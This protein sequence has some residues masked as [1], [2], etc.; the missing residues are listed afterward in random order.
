MTALPEAIRL[1]EL[2]YRVF[3]LASGA[4]IPLKDSAGCLDATDE[5]PRITAWFASSGYNI[6]LSTDGLVVVD[7]DDITWLAE[8]PDKAID[9]AKAPFQQTPR[10]G[11]HYIFRQNG[12]SVRNSASKIA[13]HIDI[14]A[15]GGY[16]VVEPSTVGGKAYAWIERIDCAPSDLP[17]PPAWLSDMIRTASTARPAA[18]ET[19]EIVTVGER[20]DWL[21]RR[22]CRYWNVS[23]EVSKVA[24]RL[25]ADNVA[26]CVPP[27]EPDE[28]RKIAESCARYESVPP[29]EP[30]ANHEWIK[31]TDGKHEL[32][33][34]HISVI[35]TKLEVATDGWPRRVGDLLFVDERGEI[36][37]LERAD[38]VYSWMHGKAT[39]HWKTGADKVGRTLV[40]KNEFAAHL[41]QEAKAYQAVEE[42]PHQPAIPEIYYS[43]KA[44]RGY[45]AEGGALMRLLGFFDNCATEIDTVLLYAM[46]LTP[47]WGGR[48]G[49][50]PAFVVVSTDRGFGK[51]EMADAIAA[52]YGGA[53]DVGNS[54]HSDEK[55]LSRILSPDA[56]TR[57]ILRFDNV[58]IGADSATLENLITCKEIS[59]HRLYSGEAT[60]PNY[61]TT[62]ITGNS[63]R[64]SRDL[65]ERAFIIQ[66]KKP[67]YACDWATRLNRHIAEHR[68]EIMADICAALK[69]PAASV[70][71]PNRHAEWC[72]EVLARVTNNPNDVIR[73]TISRRT[74]CD[75]DIEEAA[76]IMS[77]LTTEASK[78][79]PAGDFGFLA[80]T[81]VT[82]LLKDATGEHM[83][84]KAARSKIEQHIGAGRLPGITY[85]RGQTSRGYLVRVPKA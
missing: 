85:K 58:K 55:L 72:A 43:W 28:I 70:Q 57:R 25:N 82:N 71:V 32:N 12:E 34:V 65:A 16:I 42:L 47:A 78:N 79:A 10:G 39:I 50:R 31:A 21:F 61:I 23:G 36:K 60:R 6:G 69:G 9:L 15:D 67:A 41:R 81:L 40:T 18:R 73:E 64:L 63:L 20:N 48:P 22:G 35:K 62:I 46:L 66:L 38:E 68:H 53:I 4:K 84:A 24:E 52:L 77:V 54:E 13:K 26:H 1:A 7:V 44:P 5:I 2:G 27:L 33:A 56:L 80:S 3:P 74:E 37:F 59:G 17:K 51:T 49:T 19:G 14:R 11:R 76:L 29:A 75:D 8:N 45:D 30:V 83:S